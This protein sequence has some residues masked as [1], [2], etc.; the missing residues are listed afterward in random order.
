MRPQGEMVLY[1]PALLSWQGK[2]HRSWQALCLQAD[3]EECRPGCVQLLTGGCLGCCRCAW[4]CCMVDWHDVSPCSGCW[5]R[6]PPRRCCRQ[7]PWHRAGRGMSRAGNRAGSLLPGILCSETG[8]GLS[9]VAAISS[10]SS[11]SAPAIATAS[12]VSAGACIAGGTGRSGR[13]CRTCIATVV[14]APAAV[15]SAPATVAAGM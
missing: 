8:M 12:A 10:V 4:L 2:V 11:V 9:S 3:M 13:M 1:K 7:A 14:S 5:C 6:L 15:V